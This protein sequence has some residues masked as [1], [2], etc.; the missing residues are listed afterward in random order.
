MLIAGRNMIITLY[1]HL[2]PFDLLERLARQRGQRRGFLL[3]EQLEPGGAVGPADLMVDLED[4]VVDGVVQLGQRRPRLLGQIADHPLVDDVDTR[5]DR[6]LVAWLAHPGGHDRYP[7]VVGHLPVAVGDEPGGVAP[8][9]AVRRGG[10]IVGDQDLHGPADELERGNVRGDPRF[11]PRVGERTAEHVTRERQHC[12]EQVRPGDLTGHGIGQRDRVTG[13]VDQHR[14]ARLVMQHRD[15]VVADRV[16]AEQVAVLRIPVPA[17]RRARGRVGTPGL[18]EREMPVRSHRPRHSREVRLLVLRGHPRPAIGE[19]ARQVILAYGA[20]PLGRDLVHP[21][22]GPRRGHVTMRAARC[23]HN[24]PVATA[25]Q[26]QGHDQPVI[27][28]R[29]MCLRARRRRP[30][31]RHEQ[32]DHTESQCYQESRTAL[33]TLWTG[34]TKIVYSP[35]ASPEP[36]PSRISW[37]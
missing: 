31:R 34:A 18:Q 19:Q 13:P 37:A 27:R 35:Q 14:P 9:L 24:L 33:P 17:Q 22:R 8:G 30:V 29:R 20:K 12:Q 15:Q 21:H 10:R 11:H 5:L 16:L 6:G 26:Q 2:L 28:H 32:P 23:R 25:L 4:P 3:A 1:F 36:K 7:I